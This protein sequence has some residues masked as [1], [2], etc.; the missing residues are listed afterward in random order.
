MERLVEGITGPRNEGGGGGTI[1]IGVKACTKD[2][3]KEV[4][5]SKG[6]GEGVEA[7]LEGKLKGMGLT[8]S[9]EGVEDDL[10][11]Q[12]EKVVEKGVVG[13]VEKEG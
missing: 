2:G 11:N 7:E 4:V 12:R 3:S 6:V 1:G 5:R 9:K 13:L 10:G 8:E